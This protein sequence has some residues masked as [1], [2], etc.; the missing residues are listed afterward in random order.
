MRIAWFL[1]L[2][3]MCGE[4]GFA[5]FAP[6]LLLVG[7]VAGLRARRRAARLV[8]ALALSELEPAPF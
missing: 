1:P 5:L 6:Y 8:P 4:H 3:F 2:A 7:T